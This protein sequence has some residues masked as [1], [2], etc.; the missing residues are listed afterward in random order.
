MFLCLYN[1][2][3]IRQLH[4]L[5]KWKVHFIFKKVAEPVVCVS[6]ASTYMEQ[7]QALLRSKVAE[8]ITEHKLNG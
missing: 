4:R 5:H 7:G 1:P 6:F 2:A 8:L 3:V